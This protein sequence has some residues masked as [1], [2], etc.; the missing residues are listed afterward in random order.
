MRIQFPRACIACRF[1]ARFQVILGKGGSVLAA[2]LLDARLYPIQVHQLGLNLGVGDAGVNLTKLSS[3]PTVQL[4]QF[5]QIGCGP[6]NQ[7]CGS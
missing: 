7:P 2:D 3:G 1:S 5:G 4:R 6:R